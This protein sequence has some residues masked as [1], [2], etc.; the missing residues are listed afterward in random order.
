[1]LWLTSSPPQSLLHLNIKK[2]DAK[3]KEERN[4]KLHS[5]REERQNATTSFL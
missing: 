1:M 3:E 5:P 2:S 4:W